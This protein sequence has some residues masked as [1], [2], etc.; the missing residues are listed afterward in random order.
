MKG[1][2][3][4]VQFCAYGLFVSML[5]LHCPVNVL[6]VVVFEALDQFFA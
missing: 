4:N 2:T 3:V 1:S 5:P 6:T